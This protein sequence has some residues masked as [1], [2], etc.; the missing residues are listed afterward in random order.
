VNRLRICLARTISRH[1]T[2]RH[3]CDVAQATGVRSL[4]RAKA[5][6]LVASGGDE[7]IPAAESI[8]TDALEMAG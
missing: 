5:E 4:W 2:A 8:L 1:V 3:W 7:A 6:I